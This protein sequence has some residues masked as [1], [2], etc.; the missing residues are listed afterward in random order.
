MAYLYMH[1]SDRGKSQKETVLDSKI[2]LFC[3][4]SFP[5]GLNLLI[6]V[7]VEVP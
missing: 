5:S 7:S 2:E 6:P 4:F 1:E 3:V